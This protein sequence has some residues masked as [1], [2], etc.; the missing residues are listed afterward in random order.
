[1]NRVDLVAHPDARNLRLVFER[2]EQAPVGVAVVEVVALGADALEE[3]GH[4]LCGG[5][6]GH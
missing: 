4:S 5:H 1:M 6:L 3:M 2:I